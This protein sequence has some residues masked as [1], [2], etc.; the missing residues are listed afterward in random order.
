MKNVESVSYSKCYAPP[1]GSKT[2]LINDFKYKYSI[3][4]KNILVPR[5]P[6]PTTIH[7]HK[8]M[9]SE[10]CGSVRGRYNISKSYNEGAWTKQL[11]ELVCNQGNKCSKLI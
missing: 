7:G 3:F 5:P 8:V 4:L 10:G 11:A 9:T 1:L 6:P 2:S